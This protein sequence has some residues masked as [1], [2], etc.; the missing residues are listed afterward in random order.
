M[1]NILNDQIEE[2][3]TSKKKRDWYQNKKKQYST[4]F[5]ECGKIAQQK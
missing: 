4:F 2:E 5:E 3:S 1:F